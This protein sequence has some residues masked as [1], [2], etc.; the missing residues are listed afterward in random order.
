MILKILAAILGACILGVVLAD[1][2]DVIEDN[3]KEPKTKKKQKSS[4]K[5]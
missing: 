2:A 1:I 4:K 5:K 3:S